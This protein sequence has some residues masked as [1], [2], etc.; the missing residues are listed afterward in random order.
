MLTVLQS[1][2]EYVCQTFSSQARLFNYN[3]PETHGFE[4]Q[5]DSP[6]RYVAR[7]P[8]RLYCETNSSQDQVRAY[9]KV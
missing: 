2:N 7:R 8:H 1:G 9:A 5:T 4:S 3:S 6:R